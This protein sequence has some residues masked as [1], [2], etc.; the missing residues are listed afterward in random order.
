MTGPLNIV[1][2]IEACLEF[3]QSHDLLTV[4]GCTDQGRNDWG[5]LRCPIERDLDSHDEGIVCCLID[6]FLYRSREQ[7][8]WV[9]KENVF[10][11]NHREDAF[12]FFFFD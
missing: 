6:E 9:V 10:A 8:V 12:E 7:F 2:F 4:F 11:A 5:I 3:N 1:A